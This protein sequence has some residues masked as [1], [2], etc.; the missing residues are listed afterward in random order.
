MSDRKVYFYETIAD[1]TFTIE[2]ESEAE[3]LHKMFCDVFVSGA[4]TYTYSTKKDIH[5]IE[6][7]ELT[8]SY[9]FGMYSQ[10]EPKPN[11][12]MHFREK[13]TNKTEELIPDS[14]KTKV[15]EYY[16]YFYVDFDRQLTAVIY[17]KQASGFE[18]VM[19]EYF[20]QSCHHLHM[21]SY[22]IDD[23]KSAFKKFNKFSKVEY[24][25]NK[26]ESK[27]QMK[28]LSELNNLDI[29]VN[30]FRIQLKISNTGSH[31]L[32]NISQ[33]DKKKY[34]SFKLIGESEEAIQQSFDIVKRSF[35][36]SAKIAITDNPSKDL[37]KIKSIL[38]SEIVKIFDN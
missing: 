24:T 3:R 21:F 16:T 8:E 30:S 27:K 25:Y 7:K 15:L 18:K 14:E 23:I 34:S 1:P 35:M 37:E 5:H 26:D 32:E 6:V 13:S 20:F 12:F 29:E 38:S 9:A 36:R 33:L 10:E 19:M 4:T 11:P 31:F 28:T 17:N 2:G 22:S